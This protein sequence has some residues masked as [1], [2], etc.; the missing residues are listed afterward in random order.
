MKKIIFLIALAGILV[1][2]NSCSTTGYVASEPSYVEFQRPDWVWNR[3]TNGYVHQN[4]YW[5]KPSRG[6]VYVSGSWKVTPQ[7]HRWE[8]G[9]WQR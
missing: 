3:Q 8:S 4:G 9:H 1:F 7:G 5:H 6:R 2:L